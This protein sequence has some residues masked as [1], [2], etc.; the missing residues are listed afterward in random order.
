MHQNMELPQWRGHGHEKGVRHVKG[1]EKGVRHVKFSP[2]ALK[3]AS[4]VLDGTVLVWRVCTGE[5]LL[6]FKG[7]QGW[8]SRNLSV[9]SA[10]VWYHCV[11]WSHNSKL[12]A[13][14]D[15]GNDVLVWE[16]ETG[17]Q[18]AD[19][20]KGHSQSV[21]CAV[22]GARETSF[23]ASGS[24]DGTV[25]IWGMEHSSCKKSWLTMGLFQ[26]GMKATIIH[27]L[28]GHT[29][30]VMSVAIS[31]C[32]TCIVSAGLDGEIRLWGIIQGRS[33]RVLK[34]HIGPVMSVSWSPDGHYVVS[35]EEMVVCASGPCLKRCG[36]CV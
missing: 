2:D 1:H 6:V 29:R 9:P 3:L 16:A 13:S 22:F 32:N 12:V 11:S 7:N 20:L 23:V 33:V 5:K 36:L 28:K 34:G 30:G 4:A 8:L 25:L 10:P 27:R 17:V 31:P 24:L 14:A 21:T 26:K 18:V 19:P 15:R 35:R